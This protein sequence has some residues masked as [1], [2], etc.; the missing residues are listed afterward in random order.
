LPFAFPTVASNDA[1]GVDY[2]VVVDYA[3][4]ANYPD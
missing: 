1:V 4:A 3:V 2:A